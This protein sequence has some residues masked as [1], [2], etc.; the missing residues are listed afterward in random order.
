VQ[1]V[2]VWINGQVCVEVPG[3]V[4]NPDK[5]IQMIGGTSNLVSLD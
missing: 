3:R 4:E 5:L 2:N 1:N